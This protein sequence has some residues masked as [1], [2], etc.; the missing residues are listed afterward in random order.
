MSLY[1]TGCYARLPLVAAILFVC[2]LVRE[3]AEVAPLELEPLGNHQTSVVI[4]RLPRPVIIRMPFKSHLSVRGRVVVLL[5]PLQHCS[6]L[7]V[8]HMGL[9]VQLT[10]TRWSPNILFASAKDNCGVSHLN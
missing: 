3:V 4:I 5:T 10:R 7:L 1:Y 9:I 8:R 2:I 6:L